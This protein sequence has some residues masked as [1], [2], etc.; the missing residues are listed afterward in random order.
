MQDHSIRLEDHFL[1]VL[2][3]EIANYERIAHLFEDAEDARFALDPMLVDSRKLTRS[4]IRQNKV[5]VG[6]RGPY[7]VFC[8]RRGR[9]EPGE[10]FSNSVQHWYGE[11][12]IVRAI[13]KIA[14]RGFYSRLQVEDVVESIGKSGWV[15]AGVESG[16]LDG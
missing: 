8:R 5:P 14:D 6:G 9:G 1:D 13:K 2:S 15:P 11:E 4:F 3:V 10:T 16:N 7:V 12:I